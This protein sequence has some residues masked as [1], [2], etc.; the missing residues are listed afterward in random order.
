MY[1]MSSLDKAKTVTMEI[2]INSAGSEFELDDNGYQE[3]QN[4]K[5]QQQTKK[6]CVHLQYIQVFTWWV[7][8]QVA[9]TWHLLGYVLHSSIFVKKKGK[10]EKRLKMGFGFYLEHTFKKKKQNKTNTKNKTNKQQTSTQTKTKQKENMQTSERRIH[11]TRL[12]KYSNKFF[13]D[14]KIQHLIQWEKFTP[15]SATK[16]QLS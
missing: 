2:Q 11:Y 14:F 6:S 8:L 12:K 9:F 10:E 13:L 4:R 15:L 3:K 5:Q 1:R 7:L 16:E